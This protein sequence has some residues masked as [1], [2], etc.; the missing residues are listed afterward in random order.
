MAGIPDKLELYGKGASQSDEPTAIIPFAMDDFIQ[1]VD[2]N[3][4]APTFDELIGAYEDGTLTITSVFISD[5][6][7]AEL[8]NSA[9]SEDSGDSGGDDGNLDAF[10]DALNEE[11]AGCDIAGALMGLEEQIGVVNESPFSVTTG[12]EDSG[13][14]ILGD[15]EEG[16]SAAVYDPSKGILTLTPKDQEM[17]GLGGE[18]RASYNTDKNG[19]ILS[20]ELKLIFLFPESDFHALVQ[21]QGS[22]PLAQ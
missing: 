11:Y 3:V 10:T 18:L 15:S 19:V 9:S 7:R 14:F 1:R 6:L 12:G 4:G 2:V 16:A 8:E 13:L 5:T 20:G 21:I 17:G 22:R